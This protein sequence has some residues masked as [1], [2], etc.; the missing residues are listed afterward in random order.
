ML[1]WG[2]L[3]GRSKPIPASAALVL[4]RD[5]RFAS[6]NLNVYNFAAMS[7]FEIAE[8]LHKTT[9]LYPGGSDV[10]RNPA[11]HSRRHQ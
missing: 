4:L 7:G 2:A 10:R 5:V 8:N 6:R 1:N 11:K 3:Q 9:P